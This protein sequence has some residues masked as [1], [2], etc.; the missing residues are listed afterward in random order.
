MTQYIILL[1]LFLCT[2]ICCAGI[3]SLYRR[4]Q[5]LK[6]II[7][8]ADSSRG[9]EDLLPRK[10]RS[11]VRR[12][13]FMAGF[14][15]PSSSLIFLGSMVCS[16][17]IGLACFALLNYFG[18]INDLVIALA[19]F[20]GTF[21]RA[22]SFSG[23]AIPWIVFCL[24]GC[25]PIFVV[26]QIRQKRIASVDQDLPLFLDLLS[27]LAEAG[28]S[29]DV[30]LAKILNSQP[31][32]RP[33]TMEFRTFQREISLGISRLKCF[34][35]LSQRLA[36]PSIALFV[37]ALMQSEQLGVNVAQTLRRQATDLRHRRQEKAL[38]HAQGLSV[39]LVFPLILCFLP[40]IF[41]V[42]LGPTIY[43]LVNIVGGVMGAF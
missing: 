38:L 13:L 4:Q 12:W 41:L 2:L 18:I 21:G 35:R 24:V 34:R 16:T 36:V 37:S 15:H 39:K 40:G 9:V 8:F 11:F 43:Q 6:R 31:S 30:A 5:S 42:T 22:L 3:L 27:T 28:M 10:R 25:I 1:T 23:Y 29:F 33:L 26:N 7:E 17:W 32:G 20:P 19:K 14:R